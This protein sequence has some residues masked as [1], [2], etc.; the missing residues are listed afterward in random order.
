[1][2]NRKNNKKKEEETSESASAS[3]S[4]SKSELGP[5][6]S[7]EIFD[8][9]DEG[10]IKK[11]Q[12]F[13]AKGA[14]LSVVNQDGQTPIEYADLKKNV[15][16]VFA[17]FASKKSDNDDSYRYGCVLLDWLN[18]DTINVS[19]I[20][21][22]LEAGAN[23]DWYF[24]SSANTSLHVAIAR[25]H[26]AT[27]P[28]LIKY[29]ADLTEANLPREE[30]NWKKETPMALAVR[31]GDRTAIKLLAK[32][33]DEDNDGKKGFS[34]AFINCVDNKWY[35]EVKILLRKKIAAKT[36]SINHH[37]AQHLAVKNN[38]LKM[39]KLLLDKQFDIFKK[40][41]RNQTVLEVACIHNSWECALHVLDLMCE[42]KD[43]KL[44]SI[45]TLIT[46]YEKLASQKA[47]LQAVKTNDFYFAKIFIDRK[48]ST[49]LTNNEY[50]QILLYY[51]LVNRNLRMLEM[52][53]EAGANP[54]EQNKNGETSF[55]LAKQIGNLACQKKLLAC[56]Q[57]GSQTHP[58]NTVNSF[59]RSSTAMLSQKFYSASL[60][61]SA[62]I[63]KLRE[64]LTELSVELST[65]S[66][67]KKTLFKGEKQVVPDYVTSIQTKLQK[68][69]T[70]QEFETS[71]EL[72]ESEKNT[73]NIYTEILSLL[74]I[75]E[76][77]N[78]GSLEEKAKAHELF[79]RVSAWRKYL[80]GY[81]SDVNHLEEYS[82]S[83][84]APQILELIPASTSSSNV[85]MPFGGQ[86]PSTTAVPL[87]QPFF[88]SATSNTVTGVGHQQAQLLYIY[89]PNYPVYQTQPQY[90]A[91]PLMF[92]ANQNAALPTQV[93]SVPQ[94][95]LIWEKKI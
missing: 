24:E 57:S 59:S 68:L 52:L 34:S 80:I 14:D 64:L 70:L 32:A 58:L 7:K 21:A 15:K 27:L 63:A 6:K 85:V 19:N 67:S 83:V 23:P 48:V 72:Q 25:K 9:I 10:D 43:F 38:D 28:R 49:N 71:Q 93:L 77:S 74:T 79:T 55:E 60:A 44:E 69:G 22:I 75:A 88:P 46:R 81:S 82:C 36:A 45:A 31:L 62:N 91:S 8:L 94:E 33:V 65:V 2:N 18:N 20:N 56:T 87:A 84:A 53:L 90:G 41:K 78:K 47:L 95:E 51:A 37:Y 86:V 26:Y 61:S 11:I 5:K 17:I 16:L 3:E 30:N 89:P 40:N 12:K 1:M 66:F 73:R 92:Q 76:K 4:E 13:I 50:G 35:N 42:N 39:L 29:G 54:W